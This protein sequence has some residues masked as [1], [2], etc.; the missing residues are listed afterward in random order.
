MKSALEYAVRR[1]GSLSFALAAAADGARNCW[2]RAR[3]RPASR[4]LIDG[5][6][7]P[8]PARRDA[9]TASYYRARVLSRRYL[10]AEV[11]WPFP[12][13]VAGPDPGKLRPPLVLATFHMGPLPALGALV[14][15]LPGPAAIVT[16]RPGVP[17]R[18]A[19]VLGSEGEGRR[20]AAVTAAARILRSGGFALLV[21]DGPGTARVPLTLFG[22]ESSVSAGAFA[23]ARLAGAPVLPIA[24]RWQGAGVRFEYGDLIPSGAA[25]VMA[26]SVAAWLEG[27]LRRNPGELTP[28]VARLLGSAGPLRRPAPEAARSVYQR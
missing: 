4:M 10:S 23:L 12:R 28:P 7:F 9:D 22:H 14:Q 16:N 17:T 1:W 24:A 21:L 25:E 26:A 6:E 18:R 27:Y 8:E 3:R 5:V 2:R 13:I 19:A 20:V 11:A 15:R